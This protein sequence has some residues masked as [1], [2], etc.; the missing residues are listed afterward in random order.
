[1]SSTVDVVMDVDADG[2][3][4][5][6]VDENSWIPRAPGAVVPEVHLS[7][8]DVP[9]IL[10]RLLTEHGGPLQVVLHDGGR[11]F[12]DTV[13]RDRLA[14]LDPRPTGQPEPTYTPTA[15]PADV[16]SRPPSSLVRPSA[17]WFEAA[18][19]AP[20]EQV[21]VAVI[22]TRFTADEHGG[23][24]FTL[25]AALRAMVGDVI[26][27]GEDSR[28]VYVNQASHEPVALRAIRDALDS[29]AVSDQ[30]P[31]PPADLDGLNHGFRRRV[32]GPDLS[33]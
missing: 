28:E 4:A 7:R 5:V 12:S 19:Y 11:V 20:G 31:G 23:V 8:S 32:D 15:T 14:Y 10:D 21:A 24:G 16:P 29:P 2:H 22:V 26:A 9:W 1:M 13:T 33:R 6:T 25:P 17:G 18:G 30:R 3:V 27:I